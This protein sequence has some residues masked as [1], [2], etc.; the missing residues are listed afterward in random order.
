[1]NKLISTKIK[2]LLGMLFLQTYS[3]QSISKLLFICLSIPVLFS[4]CGKSDK[5]NDE[6]IGGYSI[7]TVLIDSKGHLLNMNGLMASD[8]DQGDSMF[9]MFNMFDHSII[10]FNLNSKEYVKNFYFEKEGPNG[11]GEYVFGVQFLNDSLFFLKSNSLSSIVKR[12]GLVLGQLEWEGA[13]FLAGDSI[14]FL[15]RYYEYVVNEK[16]PI[17][18]ALSLD[19]KKQKAFL[20]VMNSSRKTIIRH[21]VDPKKSFHDFFFRFDDQV[22]FI[23][24]A[25]FFQT[26]KNYISISHEFSNEVILFNRKGDFV[27]TVEYEPKLTPKRAKKSIGSTYQ[28]Q[29][30]I[31]VEFQNILEQVKYEYPVYDKLNDRYF[32]I[33]KKRIFTDVYEHEYSLVPVTK[34]VRV[35]VSVFDHEFNLV[36][37]FEVPELKNE[38]SKYFAKDGKLWVSQ[39][40]SDEL[41]FIV[42]DVKEN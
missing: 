40:F 39:N 22:N 19:F 25:V 27:K 34:A 5:G 28:T 21:D 10:E 13:K 14:E 4:S 36:S 41:G 29:D 12:D 31:R 20:D 9:Y 37:E 23:N 1:M 6:Q 8:L 16:E 3:F 38:G 33:S 7:D 35:F 2:Y 11:V 18:F 15:P 32:R 17:Y 26:S 30:E 42:V 24:P